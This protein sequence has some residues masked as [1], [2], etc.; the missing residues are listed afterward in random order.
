VG[1]IWRS[2]FVAARADPKRVQ[3]VA[4]YESASWIPYFWSTFKP[5][6]Q[7]EVDAIAVV[8]VYGPRSWNL[9]KPC[10]YAFNEPAW[11]R[12]NQNITYERAL[13]LTRSSVLH[14]DFTHNRWA[15][16]LRA[17]GKRLLALQGGPDARMQAPNYSMVCC[18]RR[19]LPVCTAFALDV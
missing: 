12:S 8:G 17:Q 2:A 4:T 16:Q 13:K 5:A 9:N 7:A 1:R 15:S 3:L 14:A 6:E 10:H 11:L 19:Y 18:V